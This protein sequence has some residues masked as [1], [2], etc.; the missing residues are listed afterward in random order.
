ML[1]KSKTKVFLARP[2]RFPLPTG[3]QTRDP[4]LGQ[5][6]IQYL[7]ALAAEGVTKT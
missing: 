7:L 4:G 6:L 3:Y 1:D 2:W 5:S